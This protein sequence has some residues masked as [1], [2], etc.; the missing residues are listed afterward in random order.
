VAPRTY[1]QFCGLAHALDLLGER[2]TLLIVRELILGPRRYGELL[3]ALPGIGTNL[4]AARLKSLEANGVVERATLPPPANVAVYALT[5]SGRELM[6]I[7]G[8]LALWG[9]R[10]LDEQPGG[11][12]KRASWAA[13]AMMAAARRRG[14]RGAETVIDLD[15]DGERLWFRLAPEGVQ[16]GEGPP[17]RTANVRL[18]GETEAF[19]ALGTGEATLGELVETG[20]LRVEGSMRT[21]ERALAVLRPDLGEPAAHSS[22]SSDPKGGQWQ[23]R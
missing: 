2:W 9:M 13:L 5:E 11:E 17:P 8:G 10:L 16:L 18:A 15:L 1:G 4:L 12:A 20:A 3:R 14:W 19:L 7:V 6:P 22:H 23:A 21:L